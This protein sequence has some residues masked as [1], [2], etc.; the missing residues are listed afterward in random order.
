MLKVKFNLSKLLIIYRLSHL[1]IFILKL[2]L[3]IETYIYNNPLKDFI[4]LSSIDGETV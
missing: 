3:E 2:S 4:Y 1:S